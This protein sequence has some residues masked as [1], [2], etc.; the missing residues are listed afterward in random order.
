MRTESLQ[1]AAVKARLCNPAVQIPITLFGMVSS[2]GERI[3]ETEQDG[4]THMGRVVP[5]PKSFHAYLRMNSYKETDMVK[6]S[7]NLTRTEQ[8]QP[9]VLHFEV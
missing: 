5:N 1:D 7:E 3:R 4:C 8:H 2:D 6:L 9:Q